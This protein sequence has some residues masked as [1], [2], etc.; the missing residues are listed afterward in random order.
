MKYSRPVARAR[1]RLRKRGSKAVLSSQFSVLSSQ[2]S[3]I[4]PCFS[5]DPL[6]FI[7][8]AV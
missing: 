7:L 3:V 4:G 1:R 6:L 8:V 5:A 2:F